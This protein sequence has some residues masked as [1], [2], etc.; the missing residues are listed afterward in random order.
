MHQTNIISLPE[1]GYKGVYNNLVPSSISSVK[2]LSQFSPTNLQLVRR[3]PPSIHIPENEKTAMKLYLSNQYWK[4]N[5]VGYKNDV[6]LAAFA[7]GRRNWDFVKSLY[8]DP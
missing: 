1:K 3:C 6:I 8:I 4:M 5:I 7:N 2:D